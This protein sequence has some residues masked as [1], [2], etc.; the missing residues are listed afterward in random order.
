[1]K[2]STALPLPPETY[3]DIPGSRGGLARIDALFGGNGYQTPFS[4]SPLVLAPSPAFTLAGRPSAR[5]SSPNFGTVRV[6]VLYWSTMEYLIDGGGGGCLATAF[7]YLFMPCV[8]GVH[9]VAPST[10]STISRRGTPS[11]VRTILRA[12]VPS[13]IGRQ[14]LITPVWR[15]TGSLSSST[16]CRRRRSRMGVWTDA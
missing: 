13:C 5:S 1:M 15:V 9:G 2:S 10:S 12:T 4:N 3:D 6:D 11:S 7:F 16:R 8:R 14:I